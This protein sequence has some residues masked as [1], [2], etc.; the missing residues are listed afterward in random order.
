MVWIFAAAVLLL[1]LFSPR[2]R[3]FG[4]ALAGAAILVIVGLIPVA[5]FL[6]SM[7]IESNGKTRTTPRQKAGLHYPRSGSGKSSRPS[8]HK[9][10]RFNQYKRGFT[11]IRNASA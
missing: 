11:M 4:L 1:A 3:K 10:T 7:T 9:P 2:F 6:I 8:G 5:G